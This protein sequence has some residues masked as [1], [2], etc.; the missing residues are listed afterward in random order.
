MNGIFAIRRLVD[1][2]SHDGPGW[3]RIEDGVVTERGDGE[4]PSAPVETLDVVVPGAV[5]TH[6]HGAVGIDLATP[7]VDPQPALDHHH[8]AGS[9]TLIA[10]LAT[11]RID[12]TRSRVRELAPLVGE[13]RLAGL[14]LEGPWISQARRGAHNPALLRE[15]SRADVADLLAAGDG[16]VRMVTIAPELPG[17]F[18][19]I[20]ELVRA[21]VVVA[22]GHTDADTDTVHRAVD[23]GARVTTHLFNGMAPMHHRQAGTVGVSLSDDR[24]TVELIGDGEHVS[25]EVIDVARRAATGRMVLV[26]DAMS[27]TGLG[28]GSYDLAGSEVVVAGG[29]AVLKEGNSLAGSTTELVR[30]AV[31]LLNRG[32]PLPEVVAVSSATAAGVFGLGGHSLLPGEPADLI[33]LHFPDGVAEV[34]R[35]ARRGIWLS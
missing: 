27:A 23:A 34:A 13:G 9:T 12:D 2:V 33:E 18:D 24:V 29:V 19:A 11:G 26:S 20:D 7:G 10:S 25:A 8:R 22:I 28:D 15:P 31:S 35:V 3:L 17:A 4:P 30:A 6:M 1:A 5:D 14:H 16:A 21:G 32:V